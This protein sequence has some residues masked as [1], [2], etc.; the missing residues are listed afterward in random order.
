MRVLDGKPPVNRSDLD[1]MLK[2]LVLSRILYHF[3]E[4][5]KNLY[6]LNFEKAIQ[7]K[8]IYEEDNLID[9][10]YARLYNAL[11]G[12]PCFK[13][14]VIALLRNPDYREMQIDEYLAVM[15]PMFHTG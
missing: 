9:F 2:D 14:Y 10:Q 5:T 13:E 11:E 7:A 4:G 6:P 12:D 1:V 15:K 8:D 3:I